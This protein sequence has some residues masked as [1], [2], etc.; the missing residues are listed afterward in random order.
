MKEVFL[1]RMVVLDMI[2]QTAGRPPL[3]LVEANGEVSLVPAAVFA[4]IKGMSQKEE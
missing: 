3:Y 2:E 1:L 4:V